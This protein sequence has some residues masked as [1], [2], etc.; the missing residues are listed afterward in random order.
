MK[1]EKEI[2]IYAVFKD[3]VTLKYRV[4]VFAGQVHE[5]SDVQNVWFQFPTK[6]KFAFNL[7][8]VRQAKKFIRQA[9]CDK[10]AP[11]YACIMVNGKIKGIWWTHTKKHIETITINQF[12]RELFTNGGGLENAIFMGLWRD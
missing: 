10:Q 4:F 7:P 3:S 11:E 12:E 9:F 1:K 2:F 5:G 8:S 6:K